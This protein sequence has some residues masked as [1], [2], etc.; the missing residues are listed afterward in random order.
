[1]DRAEAALI[2]IS[3]GGLRFL[4]QVCGA[5]MATCAMIHYGSVGMVSL[6]IPYAMREMLGSD[7]RYLSVFSILGGG[8]LLMV[9]RTVTSFFSVEGTPF[10]VAFAVEFALIPIFA[11]I[12]VKQRSNTTAA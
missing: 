11:L 6:V 9:C 2:G 10:P 7:F 3:G 4:A 5:V 12:L 1:M 8:V